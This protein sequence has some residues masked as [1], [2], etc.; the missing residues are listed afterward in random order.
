MKCVIDNEMRHQMRHLRMVALDIWVIIT[1]MKSYRHMC[2]IESNFKGDRQV[3]CK[4]IMRI[5]DGHMGYLGNHYRYI[6]N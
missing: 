5:A 6:Y 3:E 1:A 4:E 2:I